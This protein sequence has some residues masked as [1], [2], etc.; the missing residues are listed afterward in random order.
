M[1]HPVDKARRE[2][3]PVAARYGFQFSR[4]VGSAHLQWLGPNGA[5]VVTSTEANRDQ[6]KRYYIKRDFK[7]EANRRKP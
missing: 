7:R 5:V 3:E 6:R 2:L 4:I 1:S